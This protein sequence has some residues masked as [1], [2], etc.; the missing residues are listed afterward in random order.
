MVGLMYSGLA[1]QDLHAVARFL[2]GG[3]ASWWGL[4]AML[5][6][7]WSS[8]TASLACHDRVVAADLH[9]AKVMACVW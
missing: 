1:W 9:V 3:L 4:H 6:W 2:C 7:C 8:V 5:G